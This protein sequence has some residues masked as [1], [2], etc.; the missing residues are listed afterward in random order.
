MHNIN[1][2]FYCAI[3]EMTPFVSSTATTH[4][5]KVKIL[6]NF[7]LIVK[8]PSGGERHPKFLQV[9]QNDDVSNLM[10]EG[11]STM[12]KISTLQQNCLQQL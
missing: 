1:I 2:I 12:M 8:R 3:F 9:F 4:R 11:S 5:I 7:P 6:S 10:A